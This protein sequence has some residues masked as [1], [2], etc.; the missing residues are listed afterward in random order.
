[1]A[2]IVKHAKGRT[3]K[4]LTKRPAT[5]LGRRAKAGLAAAKAKAKAKA[6]LAAKGASSKQSNAVPNVDLTG[7]SP[8]SPDAV[9]RARKA[10]QLCYASALKEGKHGNAKAAS[11]QWSTMTAEQKQP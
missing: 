9:P 7:D 4:G 3:A 10:F 11:S 1:M 5:R 6:G 8:P 2:K